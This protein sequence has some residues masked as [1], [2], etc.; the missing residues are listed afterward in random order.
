MKEMT[1]AISLLYSIPI[2]RIVSLKDEKV[3]LVITKKDRFVLKLIPYPPMETGFIT[4]AMN[5]LSQSGF[6]SFNELIPTA[7]GQM[8]GRFRNHCTLLTKELHGHIPS[9]KKKEDVTAIASYLAELHNAA[10]HFFPIHRFEQRIKWGTMIHTME[11]SRDDLIFLKETVNK[12]E[13]KDAFD[14]SFLQYCDH[15]I[16]EIKRSAE[17]M[18]TFYPQLCEEKQ[19]YGGFCHHDPAYH[20]FLID[21][22]GTVGA[23]DFDYAIADLSA[24]DCAALL[25]K[26]LKTNHWELSAGLHC[27]GNY[28]RNRH[29]DKNELKFIYWLLAYPYDFHH[30]AFA[31]Y[32]EEN[33]QHRIEK[34]LF[35]LIRE[36]EKRE[37]L[38]QAIKPY[39]LEEP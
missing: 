18:N 10:T 35:R 3:F 25:L 28:N 31:R 11:Q 1:A 27:L 38:L 17:A 26:V 34:K 7:D 39:L 13:E 32:K 16:E 8:W 21:S 29:L 24:H 19:P 9:Y 22:N 14:T 15:Y 2:S 36:K 33:H 4:D 6:H 30:A 20:N 5:Y 12:K 23:F 37:A